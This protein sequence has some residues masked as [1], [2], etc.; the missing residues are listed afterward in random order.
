MTRISP[1][2]RLAS[3]GT[4]D[5]PSIP[6]LRVTAYSNCIAP[7]GLPASRTLT[8]TLRSLWYRLKRLVR[9]FTILCLT[10]GVTMAP[11]VSATCTGNG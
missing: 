4:P 1:R 8:V 2:C 7:P 9:F 5:R 3:S 6:A 10:S 11:D